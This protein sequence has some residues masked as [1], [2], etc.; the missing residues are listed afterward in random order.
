MLDSTRDNGLGAVLRV[1]VLYGP[2]DEGKGNKESAVNSLLD[3][4]H[5]AQKENVVMDDWGIRYPT[6][7]TDVGRVCKDVCE[8]FVG[9][10]STERLGME[11]T[12][13]F[14]AEERF[15]KYEIC[16]VLAEI[17]GLPVGG[18]VANKEGNEPGGVQRPF[19][20]HLSNEALRGIGVDAGARDFRGWWRWEVKAFRR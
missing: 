6:C 16:A 8:R 10:Q 19:D 17:M 20:C 11:R 13:Q 4:V 5:K 12:L 2:V 7:T 14:S 15:T 3:A 1:P 18:L 9:R